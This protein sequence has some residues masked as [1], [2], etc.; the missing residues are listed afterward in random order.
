MPP[1]LG[2]PG[3]GT[4]GMPNERQSCMAVKVAKT[5]FIQGYFN[6][7]KETSYSSGLNSGY[8][9]VFWELV[10]KEQGGDQWMETY[11]E[12]TAGVRGFWLKTEQGDE[13]SPGR[14]RRVRILIIYRR[15]QT[16]RW[17]GLVKLLRK[18]LAKTRSFKKR[19]I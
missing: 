14:W 10:A 4:T 12:D 13:T 15:N 11:E 8:S 18:I 3:A 16:W 7:G 2:R 5:D 6:S 17:E 19:H 9:V 1:T